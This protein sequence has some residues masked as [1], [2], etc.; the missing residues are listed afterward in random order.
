M[1]VEDDVACSLVVRGCRL[2]DWGWCG[3]TN[4]LIEVFLASSVRFEVRHYSV[5]AGAVEGFR[6]ELEKY[7]YVHLPEFSCKQVLCSLLRSMIEELRALK[8]F[9]GK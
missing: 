7:G 5:C 4:N 9:W 2:I 8:P 1:L 3:S 6:V